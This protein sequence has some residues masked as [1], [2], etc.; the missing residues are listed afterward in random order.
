MTKVIKVAKIGESIESIDPN[1]Y[2]F[3]SEYNTFKI[4]AQG[5]KQITL[6][7]STNNQSF[8][9]AH[10]LGFVPLISAFAKRDSA[11]Q[12]FLPNSTDVEIWGAKLGMS[13]D[14]KF[15]YVKADATN[16]TFNFDNAKGSTVAITIQYYCLEGVN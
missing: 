13:G 14:V 7:A 5:Q 2:V 8:T 6:T 9:E 11:S 16:I 12:V 4:V 10:G 15:N 3:H 1:D